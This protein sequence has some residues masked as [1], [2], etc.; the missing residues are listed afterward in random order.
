MSDVIET[1]DALHASANRLYW[2]SQEPVDRL[3]TR[4]GMSRHAFYASVRP[5]PAGAGCACGG[6]LEFSNRKAR[7]QGR[8]R[9]PA[10]GA[11]PAVA[12]EAPAATHD[13]PPP[14]PLSVGRR[15]G[16]GLLRTWWRELSMVRPERAAMIGGAAALGLATALFA[17][18]VLR[19]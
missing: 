18:D 6:A 8:V 14:I 7:A 9:C 1:A 5:M 2:Q 11:A 12:A 19:H 3:A 17:T 16:A 4:L 13:S 10:C 15:R